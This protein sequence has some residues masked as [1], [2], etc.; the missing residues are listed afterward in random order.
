MKKLYISLAFAALLI[1]GCSEKSENKE[2]PTVLNKSEQKAPIQNEKENEKVDG[3]YGISAELEKDEPE[4]KSDS[5]HQPQQQQN[6]VKS[7]KVL[8]SVDAGGYTYVKVEDSGYV[9]WIAG[10]KTEVVV[11]EMISYVPQM[12]M[13]NFH[14]NTLNRDF[15]KVLFVAVIAPLKGDTQANACE[16][17]NSC[18]DTN[19]TSL[20][21]SK[22]AQKAESGTINI[23]KPQDG[24]SIAEIFEK[25]G[26]LKD[27]N[28]KVKGKV[29][30]VSRGIMG[31]DWV[32]ITDDGKDDLVITS[33]SANVET[34]EVVT[35]IGILKTDVDLGYGYFFPVI[36]EEAKFEK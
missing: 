10:P 14:S 22:S 13:E 17:C 1:S 26:E 21:E 24:Y 35:V 31:K 23:E 16:T 3:V 5:F 33:P 15:D 27:K 20:Q 9:Y 30:K 36:I 2:K 11:G 4:V 19:Q 12:W 32:H 6:G 18:G 29:T 8:E 28:V 34:G 25:K 7:G